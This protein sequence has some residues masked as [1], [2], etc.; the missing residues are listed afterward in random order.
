MP[1]PSPS[2]LRPAIIAPLLLGVA[3]VGSQMFIVSPLLPDIARDLGTTVS[4][5][6]V[7]VAGG[8]LATGLA[9]A[10]A[11]P[12]LDRVPRKRVLIGALAAQTAVVLSISLAPTPAVFM[13]AFVAA[14]ALNGILLPTTYAIASDIAP[15]QE[16]GRL[17]GLV[18]LGWSASFLLQPLVAELGD[19]LGW[20]GSYAIVAAF[21]GLAGL[22]DLLLPFRPAA[23]T[24]TGFLSAYARALRVPT[25]ASLLGG[26]LFM[27]AAFYGCYPYWGA[28][29]RQS[30]GGDASAA[31][32][33]AVGFG[34]G[35]L[36]GG[37]NARLIDRLTPHR[38]LALAF[39]AAASVYLLLPFALGH[40]LGFIAWC[41][42]IGFCN[43]MTLT[44][45]VAALASASRSERGGILALYAATT[46]A[47]FALGAAAMGPVF[48]ANGLAVVG[49]CSA[50][51]LAVAFL[52]AVLVLRSRR[53]LA[54]Q[55]VA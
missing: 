13:L 50:A 28:A 49:L 55:P 18:L 43:N 40:R 14:G 15:E 44:S 11:A 52:F 54:E 37:L 47:G 25:V 32:V 20:R 16:R 12:F 29:Y 5:I 30:F 34:S 45:L 51:M 42:T 10:L 41:A 8:S 46:Y 53:R 19:K 33:L 24:Q 17:L 39:A 26:C 2:A 35:F 1:D 3:V 4:R 31:S 9:A 48:E 27:M 7:A 23:G 38:M 6:G 22:L 21:A 36:V